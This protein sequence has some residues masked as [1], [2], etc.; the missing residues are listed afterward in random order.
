M[1]ITFENGIFLCLCVGGA[2]WLGPSH[3]V[4]EKRRHRE[5]EE[6]RASPRKDKYGLGEMTRTMSS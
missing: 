2:A 1:N 6:R 5:R 3:A 4:E